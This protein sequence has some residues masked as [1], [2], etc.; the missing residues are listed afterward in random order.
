M[1]TRATAL[2]AGASEVEDPAAPASATNPPLQHPGG[3]AA[4]AAVATQYGAT[5][6]LVREPLIMM[7]DDEPT[8]TEVLQMFLEAAGYTKFVTRNDSRTAI[9]ALREDTPDV[10]LLDLMM[11]EVSGF[12]ILA[13]MREDDVLRHIPVI[14]LTSSVDAETK[15]QALELGATDF[16][17]KPVDPSELALR[18]RNTLRAK[19]HQDRLAHY[20]ALTGLPNRALCQGRLD[21]ALAATIAENR[22]CA[23][24]HVDLDRFRRVN[25]SLGQ[26]MGDMV[27]KSVAQ[28]LE[29]V[30]MLGDQTLDL[31]ALPQ[32]EPFVARLGADEFAIVMPCINDVD[33]VTR[34]ASRV[35]GAF[36]QP[37]VL[38]RDDVFV[39]AAVGIAMCPRDGTRADDLLQKAASATAHAKTHGL[40]HHQFYSSDVTEH[41]SRRLQLETLLYKAVENDQLSIAY[42]PKLAVGN[43]AVVGAEALLR[44]TLPDGTSVSPGEFIPIA[45]ECG[46][47]VDVGASVLR[48]AC[49]Q[50]RDWQA[51]GLSDINLA[52]NVSAVQ[53]RDAAFL[54]VLEAALGDA[55]I[56]GTQLTVEVTEGVLM[57]NADES[58]RTL[59]RIRELGPRISI[60][61]F[62][63]GYSSLAYLKRFAIDELKIDGSFIRDIPH[64]PDNCAIVNAVIGLSHG[65]GL[66]VVAEG[67]EE[68]TQHAFLREHGCNVFQGFLASRALPPAQFL[69][70]VRAAQAQGW[71]AAAAGA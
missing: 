8:T 43:D 30:V 69:A 59:S 15:L 62:G 71:R 35:R 36:L 48:M 22:Q 66:R 4:W 20:D 58:T 21:A 51:A 64:D 17:G 32:S 1:N 24:L 19:A 50:L 27:L 67:V 53:F 10:L 45:E 70:F 42:Q 11:P 40:K 31:A 5:S 23:V 13:A 9:D 16:L 54:D 29:G 37:F 68:E 39:T 12:E 60:D 47:I 46:L 28:R 25:D 57:N 2:S 38:V 26:K 6:D 3:D 44:W 56:N 18:L 49:R 63:T 52:V 61:D 33:H 65:L 55:G 34:T 7:V 41:A 14:M